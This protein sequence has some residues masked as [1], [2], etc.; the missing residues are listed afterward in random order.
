MKFHSLKGTQDIL[1]EQN[2]LW[3]EIERKAHTLFA[4]YGYQQIQTPI[5]EEAS[6]FVRSLGEASDVVEKQMYVFQD[7]GER[8]IAL[9]PE[10][11]AGVVR[12]YIENNLDKNIGFTKLYYL[13][14]MF[15]SENPQAGRSSQ[16][17]QIGVEAIG[18]LC[19]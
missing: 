11:T 9:R 7:R 18:S 4:L 1:P 8:L 13:G 17:H 6:L 19:S 14:A 15:R 16:F 2:R 10:A 3:Q 12:A 5:I